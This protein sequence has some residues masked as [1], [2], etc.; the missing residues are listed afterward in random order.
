FPGLIGEA[1]V[2]DSIRYIGT[3]GFIIPRNPWAPDAH[4]K[5]LWH[6]DEGAG[7]TTAD[8]SG[9]GNT[10]VFAND[11]I[12]TAD[13]PFNGPDTIPPA[14]SAITVEK[15]TTTSATITWTTDEP[16]TSQVSYGPTAAYGNSTA[17]DAALVTGHQQTITNLSASTLYDFQVVSKDAAGNETT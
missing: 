10:G 9:N 6:L 16:A 2:S 3:Q 7:T 5:G 17:F 4:T 11:P 13:S 12:W 1:R 15:L 14:T 8:V